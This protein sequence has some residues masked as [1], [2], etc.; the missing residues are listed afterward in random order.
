MA[1]AIRCSFLKFSH[2]PISQQSGDV[3]YVHLL[4][5][6]RRLLCSLVNKPATSSCSFVNKAA[7]SRPEAPPWARHCL[8]LPAEGGTITVLVG[9]SPAA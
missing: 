4:T 7:T 1:T 5:K 6:R 8:E 3:L 2:S 9:R